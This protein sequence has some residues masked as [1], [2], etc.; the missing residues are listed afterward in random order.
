MITKLPISEDEELAFSLLI[1]KKYNP[2]HTLSFRVT[3]NARVCIVFFIPASHP[4]PK[5]QKSHDQ[6]SKQADF[7]DNWL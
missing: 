4:Y 7:T 6:E 3:G 5:K 2:C 1:L